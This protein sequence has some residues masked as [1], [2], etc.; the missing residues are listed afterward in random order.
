MA[1][2]TADTDLVPLVDAVDELRVRGRPRE[3]DGSRVD[4][5]GLHVAGGD[6]G[7]CER[8]GGAS[9]EGGVKKKEERTDTHRQKTEVFRSTAGSLPLTSVLIAA[10]QVRAEAAIALLRMTPR[11]NTAALCGRLCGSASCL[12]ISRETEPFA[13]TKEL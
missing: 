12:R 5:L 2:A 13:G 1:A 11:P 8:G 7:H 4:R 9:Y 6:G 3:T 10:T